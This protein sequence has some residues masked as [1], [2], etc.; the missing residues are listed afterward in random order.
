M[1]GT[2]KRRLPDTLIRTGQSGARL[3]SITLQIDKNMEKEK[4]KEK[5]E[6]VQFISA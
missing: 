4:E 3:A 5:V 1:K 2:E 6:W